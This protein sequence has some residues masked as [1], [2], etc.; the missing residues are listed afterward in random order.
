MQ[1]MIAFACY[2]NDKVLKRQERN[3]E[4]CTEKKDHRFVYATSS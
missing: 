3:E 1:A 4:E 2:N